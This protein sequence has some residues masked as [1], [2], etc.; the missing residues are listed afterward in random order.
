MIVCICSNIND[1]SLRT[2][3]KSNR[4]KN[5]REFHKLNLCCNCAKCYK[6]INDIIKEEYESNIHK[7]CNV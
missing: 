1:F 3:I 2:L 5:V 4:I 7:N 6:E